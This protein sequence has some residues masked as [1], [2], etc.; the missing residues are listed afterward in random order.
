M[1]IFHLVL[2]TAH[3]MVEKTQAQ[4]NKVTSSQAHSWPVVEQGL[5]SRFLNLFVFFPVLD[6]KGRLD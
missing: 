1:T 5:K 4:R 6:P 3:L 2:K